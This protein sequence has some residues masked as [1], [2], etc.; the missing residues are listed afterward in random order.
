MWNSKFLDYIE[1]CLI[2]LLKCYYSH[3]CVVF[4]L[5]TLRYYR[6]LQSYWW[7][8]LY[9]FIVFAT[10]LLMLLVTQPNRTNTT[11]SLACNRNQYM[12]YKE[13]CLY[14]ILISLYD[15]YTLVF[16]I[17]LLR[18][19]IIVIIIVI[20]SASYCCCYFLQNQAKFI[21]TI[22]IWEIYSVHEAILYRSVYRC[23]RG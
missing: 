6:S 11:N 21:P 10:A 3:F 8:V 13:K 23:G 14:V 15:F 4:I 18:L 9:V 19:I 5:Y 20:I 12:M 22:S 17:N 16:C 7:N 2:D 1:V